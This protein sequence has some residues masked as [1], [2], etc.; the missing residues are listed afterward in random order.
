MRRLVIKLGTST[1][2]AVGGEPS[3]ILTAYAAICATL[4]EAGWS[5]VIVTSGAVGAGRGPLGLTGK[6]LSLVEKQ[7]AAAV[8]QSRLMETYRQH[9]DGVGLTVAQVLLSREDISER[10]RCNNARQ[11]LEFLLK[12]GVVPLINEND[13][14]ATAELKFG[15]NDLLSALVAN[16]I[17]AERLII[18]T[19]TGGLYTADPRLD[20]TATLITEVALITP[21]LLG[22]AGESRSGVGTGGMASKLMAARIASEGGVRVAITHGQQ[23][24]QI[25][26][27]VAGAPIGTTV[28]PAPS[29]RDS[30]KSWIAY[31]V[32]PSGRVVVDDGAMKA[33]L[34]DGRSLLPVGIRRVDGEFDAGEV[35]QICRADGTEIGRGV[36]ALDATDLQRVIGC[37]TPEVRR[38]LGGEAPAEAIH[39]DD[40]T[41]T[42]VEV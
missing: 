4:Q 5:P 2:T 9:F 30:R 20:P 10:G 40:L 24:E 6:K 16:L 1:V 3:P 21:E 7:A 8:G 14:V 33:M 38:R 19:D 29:R 27:L 26:D 36:V 22:M 37:T 42:A 13:T 15:D 23:P 34:S 11:A 41:M 17:G 18:M 12:A 25:M 31:G 35:V 28:L 39:R 32:V